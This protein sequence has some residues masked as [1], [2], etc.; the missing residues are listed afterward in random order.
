MGM[1][2]TLRTAEENTLYG[3]F[4]MEARNN[5]V[6]VR[7]NLNEMKMLDEIARYEGMKRTEYIRHIIRREYRRAVIN[8][9]ENGDQGE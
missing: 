8:N 6:F 2:R 9:G 3:G 7:L 1:N 5:M 4:K